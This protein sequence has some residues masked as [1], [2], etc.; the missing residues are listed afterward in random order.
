MVGESILKV[1]PLQF[2]RRTKSEYSIYLSLRHGYITFNIIY[3]AIEVLN[4]W[5]VQCLLNLYSGWKTGN[6]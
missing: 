4:S 3:S 1:Q 2:L 5:P 6:S